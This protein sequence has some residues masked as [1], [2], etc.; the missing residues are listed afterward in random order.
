MTT[1]NELK[2]AVLN[3]RHDL[4]LDLVKKAIGEKLPVDDIIRDGIIEGLKGVGD[5]F[6]SG[7]YFLPELL[8]AGQA[9]QTALDYLE[10]L[11]SSD[12]MANKRKVLIGTVKG[13]IHD[14]GKNLVIMMLKCN[15]YEIVDSGI[16]VAPEKFCDLV[17][18][19]NFDILGLSS[20]LSMTLP[21]IDETIQ[22]IETAGLR[23]KIR[24]I[25]GGAPVT[26]EFM[27]KVGADALGKDAWDAVLKCNALM[28]G[29]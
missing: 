19:G 15:G 25:I 9:A 29:K 26:P 14:L 2:D 23:E 8:V 21:M 1:L 10:P 27:E 12:V 5:L 18:E 17:R 11:L 16:D 3:C 7:K 13:D 28:D 24:I 22:K 4:I 6:N 20:L